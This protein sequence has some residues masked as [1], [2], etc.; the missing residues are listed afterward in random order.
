L[1]VTLRALAV[2]TGLLWLFLGVF[3]ATV[4]Y[5]ATQIRVEG[6]AATIRQ[7][8]ASIIFSINVTI[9]N[10]GFHDI[11]NLNIRTVMVLNLTGDVLANAS[12]TLPAIR[13]RERGVLIHE[14]VLDLAALAQKPE[15]IKVLAFNDTA[16][17][18]AIYISLT[19]AY[20]FG[21][22]LNMNSSVP[23][24]A[25]MSGL[26]VKGYQFVGDALLVNM[27]FSNHSPM[28]YE[29]WL[30]ALNDRG[31]S[32]G[33]SDKVSMSPGAAFDGAFEISILHPELWTGSGTLVAHVAI[34]ETQLSLEV[35]EYRV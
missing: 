12:S 21:T 11:T 32:L 15:V 6:M 26:V 8:D 35:M 5:S 34:G 18:L 1:E 16:I 3:L 23:W 28:G 13:K 24:G 7:E 22:V 17:D 4:I 2:A 19:Y 31:E 14:V 10:G 9:Y 29:I 20:V 25:P 27:S 33:T 30:E